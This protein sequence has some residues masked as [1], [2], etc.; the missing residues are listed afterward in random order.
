MCVI[1]KI[2]T[3]TTR[4]IDADDAGYDRRTGGKGG[5]LMTTTKPKRRTPAPMVRELSDCISDLRDVLKRLESLEVEFEDEFTQSSVR[6]K[7]RAEREA[8]RRRVT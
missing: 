5:A 1:K 4:R 2:T 7:L 8:R 6:K 3:S